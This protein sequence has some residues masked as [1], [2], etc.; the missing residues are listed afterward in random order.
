VIITPTLAPAD[1]ALLVAR[2]V[3]IDVILFEIGG[4]AFPR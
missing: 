1:V 2:A 4:Q 3:P